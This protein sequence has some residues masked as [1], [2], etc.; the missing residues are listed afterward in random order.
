MNSTNQ[1]FER[2]SSETHTLFDSPKAGEQ[3]VKI[4]IIGTGID[5]NHAVL[6]KARDQVKQ[7]KSWVGNK[8]DEDSWGFGTHTAALIL[9]IAPAS[10]LYI[11]RIARDP[12]SKIDPEDIAQV[13]LAQSKCFTMY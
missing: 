12:A 7:T 8:G 2:L 10:E 4:A 13:G 6:Q 5:M 1:W 3:R 9:R 11:A